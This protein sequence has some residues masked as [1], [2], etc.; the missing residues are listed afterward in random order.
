MTS[1]LSRYTHEFTEFIPDQ[2]TPGVLYVSLEYATCAHLCACGCGIEVVTRLSPI[3]YTVSFDGE[4]VSLDHSVGNWSYPCQ[5][6][7]F[8]HGG[9]VRWS[10]RWPAEE[11]ARGRAR[12]ARQRTERDSEREMPTD[13]VRS[14]RRRWWRRS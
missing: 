14:P 4:T 13:P 1:R 5:S 11:I 7:Y 12:T 8:L 9:L 10:G 6:H 3:D 2:L